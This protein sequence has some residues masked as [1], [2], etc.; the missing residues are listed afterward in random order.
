MIMLFIVLFKESK[1]GVWTS[2]PRSNDTIDVSLTVIDRHFT[3]EKIYRARKLHACL[4]NPSD[5]NLCSMLNN[6]T[7]LNCVERI[8]VP[9][10]SKCKTKH[11][12]VF[13]VTLLLLICLAL[14]YILL[15]LN[16]SLMEGVAYKKQS[17]LTT[18]KDIRSSV[19][20]ATLC[21]LS[22]AALSTLGTHLIEAI[23]G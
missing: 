20:L 2:N 13:T 1:N 18:L 11:L 23:S 19:S 22:C 21:V 5:T 15:K 10:L 4:G 8:S 16:Q 9:I 7:L 12:E 14:C 3:P 17:K 6:D